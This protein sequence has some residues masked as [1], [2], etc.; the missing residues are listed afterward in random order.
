MRYPAL[1]PAVVLVPALLACGGLGASVK[2]GEHLKQVCEAGG[3]VSLEHVPVKIDR[4]YVPL[5]PGFQVV[6][7]PYDIRA[8]FQFA[9]EAAELKPALEREDRI[10]LEL[11]PDTASSKVLDVLRASH[12]A[13]V[14]TVDLIVASNEQVQLPPYPDPDYGLTFQARLHGLD[15]SQRAVLGAQEIEGLI[16][17]C[18]W[19][20]EVFAAVA[21]ASPDSRCELVAYGLQEALPICLATDSDKVVTAVQVVSQ[22]SSEWRPTALTLK[23]TDDGEPLEVPAGATWKDLAPLWTAHHGHEISLP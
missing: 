9:Q 19:A 12:A 16:R 23:L 8:G 11:A 21:S 13:G 3:S 6:V 1:V 20:Q 10:L 14:K 15:A 5:E 17:L 7:G 4:P 18:P 22:P 2:P